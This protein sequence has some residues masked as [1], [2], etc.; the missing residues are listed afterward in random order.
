MVFKV[1]AAQAREIILSG[2][3]L[4]LKGRSKKK[5]ATTYTKARGAAGD[6]SVLC[7]I[8]FKKKRCYAAY[9]PRSAY[10]SHETYRQGPLADS[11]FQLLPR[12]LQW[13]WQV[14]QWQIPP[15]TCDC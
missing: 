9:R 4:R 8:G 10:A 15:V 12:S 11:Y 2:R 13:Q 3:N 6:S 5:T 14:W 7:F 1:A